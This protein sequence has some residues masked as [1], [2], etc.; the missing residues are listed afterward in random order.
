MKRR[1]EFEFEDQSSA[2]VI[3]FEYDDFVE[4][5]INASLEDGVAVIFANRQ[6][7]LALA[8]VF[9]KIA[10]SDYPKGFHLHLKKNFDADEEE[11]LRVV[12]TGK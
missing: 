4:E 7:F 3:S 2:N 10:L 9:A 12:L 1:F 6:A 5:E 8:K 11:I